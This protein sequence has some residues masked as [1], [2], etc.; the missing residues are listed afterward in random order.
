LLLLSVVGAIGYGLYRMFADMPAPAPQTSAAA[1]PKM[2]PGA[3]TEFVI[4][5]PKAD[6]ARYTGAIDTYMLRPMD[7]ARQL[8][9]DLAN[10]D[11]A[12]INDI[13]SS[14]EFS[15]GGKPKAKKGPPG[16]GCTV[17]DVQKYFAEQGFPEL[18][19]DLCW[20]YDPETGKVYLGMK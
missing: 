8:T 15:G 3:M 18:P 20:G 7:A 1:R 6:Q 13:D 2:I 14:P 19:S 11:A 5:A 16:K 10:R 17:A 12:L 9:A 4:G